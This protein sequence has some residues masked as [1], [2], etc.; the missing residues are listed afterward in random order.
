MTTTYANIWKFNLRYFSVEDL[1]SQDFKDYS[2]GSLN[3]EIPKGNGDPLTEKSCVEYIEKYKREIFM[4]I[5]KYFG[6]KDIAEDVFQDVCYRIWNLSQKKT[7]LDNNIK[8]WMFHV[9]ANVCKKERD[10]V[11]KERN[12]LSYDVEESIIDE[13]ENPESDMNAKEFAEQMDIAIR[14]LPEQLKS[15]VLL[16]FLH[17]HSQTQ[18]AEILNLSEMAVSRKLRKAYK[19]MAANLKSFAEE[20]NGF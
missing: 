20:S 9:A 5:Y 4:F 8:S 6:D 16:K 7:I 19:L 11:Y 17:N 12:K 10:R 3:S 13:R 18:I 1:D 15:V 14:N 2:E